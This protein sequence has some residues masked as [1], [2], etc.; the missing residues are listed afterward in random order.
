MRK[1]VIFLIMIIG[2]TLYGVAQDKTFYFI[3]K[4][5]PNGIYL[6]WDDTEG[7]FPIDSNISLIQLKR[8]NKVILEFEPNEIMSED[9][10]KALYS[11]VQNINSLKQVI[12]IIAKN[13]DISSGCSGANM[14]NYAT[15][16][17]EC[18]S[19]NF[20]RYASLKL[21]FNLAQVSY[22]A[23]L[24]KNTS[25]KLNTNTID[26][27]LNAITIIDDEHNQTQRL[28]KISIDPK[29]SNR[30]LSAEKFHQVYQRK[31]NAPE[32]AKD[33]YTVALT[34]KSG[35]SKTDSL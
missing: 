5:T 28:G 30:V 31:C 14:S 4:S 24:D 1:I 29:K 10:I 20:W 3:G 22:R 17:R 27:E 34:W 21:N 18:L 25:T 33:D 6:R 23:Y 35:G 7:N 26:Y 15:K 12:S 11:N 19:N 8:Y 13:S 16:I 2:V 32:Y 9:K